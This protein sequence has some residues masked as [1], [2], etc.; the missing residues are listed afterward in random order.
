MVLKEHRLLAVAAV[1]DGRL[2]KSA[3]VATGQIGRDGPTGAGDKVDEV[4]GVLDIE[5]GRDKAEAGEESGLLIGRG[6]NFTV[7]GAERFLGSALAAD[8]I[9]INTTRHKSVQG[10]PMFETGKSSVWK[11]FGCQ[12]V[13]QGPSQPERQVTEYHISNMTSL[14]ASRRELAS[15]QFSDASHGW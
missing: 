10:A 8:F 6:R 1:T 2:G 3:S 12:A 7:A 9:P 15:M 13:A 11:V 4:G 14:Y 5:S